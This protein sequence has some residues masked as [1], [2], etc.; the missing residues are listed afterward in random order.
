MPK[1]PIR[2][3]MMIR[4][5]KWS[6]KNFLIFFIFILL[7]ISPFS[8][9][10]LYVSLCIKLVLRIAENNPITIFFN[11]LLTFARNNFL[12]SPRNSFNYLVSIPKLIPL[13]GLYHTIK[14]RSIAEKKSVILADNAFFL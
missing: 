4:P 12:F 7:Q 8:S 14:M 2:T 1:T 6:L 13:T 3:R 5:S 11:S 10:C 9:C